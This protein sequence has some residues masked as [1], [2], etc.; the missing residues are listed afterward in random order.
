M[1]LSVVELTPRGRGAVSVLAVRGAGAL[2]RVCALAPRSRLSPGVLSWA[3][4]ARG[5]E[6]LDEALICVLAPDHVELHLHGSPP[7][8]ARVSELLR[9][10]AASSMAL[11]DSAH[12][13][14]ATAANATAGASESGESLEAKALNALADAPSELGARI[15]LDQVQGALRRDLSALGGLPEADFQPACTALLERGRV[16]CCALEPRVVVLTGPPNAGKSTLFNSLLGERRTLAGPLAG[17]TRDA[18]QS[19]ALL[20]PWPVSLIDTAGLRETGPEHD[21]LRQLEGRGQE[22]ARAASRRAHW[23]LEL[24]PPDATCAAQ[25]GA[26]PAASADPTSR[27]PISGRGGSEGDGRDWGPQARRS[28]LRTFGDLRPAAEREA[29]DVVLALTE[30]EQAVR[31]V[32]RLFEAAFDLPSE[33]WVPG[34]GVPFSAELRRAVEGLAGQGPGAPREEHLRALIG[35]PPGDGP[36]PWSVAGPP[37][38]E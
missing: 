18:V 1:N 23:V 10:D 17:T 4:L 25:A 2:Q 34:R 6:R 26:A 7:L 37:A 24:V 5:A 35:P 36:A 30:P 19:A 8:V 21:P 3:C 14:S 29:A 9:A 31:R 28:V 27:T 33:P 12:A 15:L 16:A 11:A 32:R 22:R 38:M 20:G 13:G